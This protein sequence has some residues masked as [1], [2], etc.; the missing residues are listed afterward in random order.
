MDSLQLDIE[1][2]IL[3]ATFLKNMEVFK[4]Y[5]PTV[6]DYFKDYQPESVR[7]TYDEQNN[8]N[9]VKEGTLVYPEDPKTQT[10]KQVE[11]FYNNPKRMIYLPNV[12]DEGVEFFKHGSVIKK[13]V[14]MR[15]EKVKDTN[16]PSHFSE[17]SQGERFIDLICFAGV[18]MGY[19][20]EKIVQENDI[21][22]AYVFEPNIDMFFASMHVVDYEPL[23][24]KCFNG[25][26]GVHLVIGK[27]KHSFLNEL[28]KFV[29]T[30]GPMHVTRMLFYRHYFSD[31]LD[32]SV[33]LFYE[34]S[35]RFTSGWGFFEDEIISIGHTLNN[36]KARIPVWT[37]KTP[38]NSLSQNPVFIVANGPSLD[39]CMEY[40]KN[41]K[42][43]AIIVS[44]G[45]A[46]Y[47]LLKND[48]L[49]DIHVEIE[50]TK[51]TYQL[52]KDIN[53]DDKLSQMN[54]V[55]LNTLYT[56]VF[57]LFKNPYICMKGNDA[58]ADLMNMVLGEDTYPLMPRCNPTVSNL[59][60]ELVVQL[61]FEQI[62]FFGTDFGWK[63]EE[64][65]H[66]KHS[67]YYDEDVDAKEK[68]TGIVVKG[69]FEET[70]YSDFHFDTSKG[71]V[72]MSIQDC[73]KRNVKVFNCAD[74]A[75]IQGA[76]PRK[77]EDIPELQEIVDK[78]SEVKALL[79]SVFNVEAYKNI[80]MKQKFEEN[81][82]FIKQAMENILTFI[83]PEYSNI[84][85]LIS[86]FTEQYWYVKKFSQFN[87]LKLAERFITGTMT[88]FQSTIVSNAYYYKDEEQLK[89]FLKTAIALFSQHIHELYEILLEGYDKVDMR[90]EGRL[91]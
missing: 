87:E 60:T 5:S 29:K 23:Y 86:D 42:K 24:K 25:V 78:E 46:L 47:S 70:V 56:D 66:S 3:R 68:K 58:G 39:Q 22:F 18:G 19:H 59:A 57:S 4:K 6:C 45:T 44:C 61:G 41:N 73:D 15:R 90:E 38:E 65:H 8:L 9:L 31:I 27:G 88:Y 74:G 1:T 76:I 34:I 2:K 48:V 50:R 52:L 49:P 40:I 77:V 30:N 80:D 14:N 82:H 20:I 32:D 36:L 85:D 71:I 11:I 75:L 28:Y 91:Y 7:L 13:I 33:K 43:K 63:D 89:I 69:N 10:Q 51:F 64:Y 37:G 72:E 21:N 79:D 84:Q 26:G 62:Y 16:H 54:L 55:A 12:D 17:G 53:F 83:K 67:R 35:Y 81:L